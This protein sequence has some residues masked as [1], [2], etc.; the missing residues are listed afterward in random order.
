ML[1]ADLEKKTSRAVL[2]LACR[3]LMLTQRGVLVTGEVPGLQ[4]KESGHDPLL[5]EFYFHV[6]EDTQENKQGNHRLWAVPRKL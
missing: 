4:I 2:L 3:P 5:V 6:G 1:C